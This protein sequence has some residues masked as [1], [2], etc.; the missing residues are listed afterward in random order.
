MVR[1]TVFLVFA[2]LFAA[3]L[4]LPAVSDGA[5]QRDVTP[6]ATPA[7]LG[8]PFEM[9]GAIPLS[10]TIR[11]DGEEDDRLLGGSSPAG[12][13]IE[14]HHTRLVAGRRTMQLLPDGLVIPAGKTL[15]LEP[16]AN[17][18]MLIGLRTDL[19]Q[20]ETFPLTLRFARAGEVTVTARVRR[21]TDA[22][23][24]TPFPPAVSGEISVSLVSA[25]P[26]AAGTPAAAVG[27]SS[28]RKSWLEI[29]PQPRHAIACC[30]RSLLRSP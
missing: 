15:V 2:M 14:V 29:V 20:G 18:L 9:P 11:N 13:R 16:G 25:P 6:A 21:K 30:N 4:A 7:V 1:A 28:A 12:E 22:P 3:G 8:D 10:L 5:F 23:G 27:P 26:A 24:I 17:H 19:V